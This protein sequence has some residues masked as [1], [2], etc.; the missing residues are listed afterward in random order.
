MNSACRFGSA[1]MPLL[2]F[3]LNSTNQPNRP[4]SFS[5]TAGL[6]LCLSLNHCVCMYRFVYLFEYKVNL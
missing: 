6:E 1:P 5:I 3:A 2:R 4:Y